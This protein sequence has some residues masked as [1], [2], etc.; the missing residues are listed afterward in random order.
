M[1]TGFIRRFRR[2]AQIYFYRE[3]AKDGKRK[4]EKSRKQAGVNAGVD[5]SIGKIG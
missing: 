4:M 2:L 1:V 3:G 5:A